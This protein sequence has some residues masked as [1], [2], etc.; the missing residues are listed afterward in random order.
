MIKLSDDIEAEAVKAAE[1]FRIDANLI[2]AIIVKESEGELF[3]PR[4][5]PGFTSLWH[6]R[7]YAEKLRISAVTEEVMQKMSWGA[8]QVMG[9]TARWQ[10]FE[11]HLPM[12][13]F[14]D[15]GIFYGSKYLK[16]LVSKFG[17]DETHV[18]AAYNAGP[19]VKKTP[20]GMYT[21]QKQ[22]VD[23]VYKYL[24]ELRALQ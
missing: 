16:W 11:S 24:S 15:V 7:D 17:E 18:I 2:R 13:C 5:E 22:Y 21:N 19:G 1:H 23:V 10:G 3:R 4:F 12:L 6:Y 20:G 9:A 8:M 14:P